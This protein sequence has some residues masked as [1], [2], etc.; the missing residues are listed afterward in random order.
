MYQGFIGPLPALH[1]FISSDGEGSYDLTYYEMVIHVMTI[2]FSALAVKHLT[3][4]SSE[5]ALSR[6]T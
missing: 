1:W 4:R 2:Y 3:R 5:D 6:A